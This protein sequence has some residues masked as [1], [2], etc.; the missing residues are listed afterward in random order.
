VITLEA[1]EEDP[2]PILARLLADEPVVRVGSMD[3]WFVTRW[4]DVEF[5]CHHPELFTAN[6]TPSWLRSVL[7]ETML[8]LDGEAHDRQYRAMKPPFAA[9]TAGSTVR[10][11]LPQLFDGLIDGFVDRGRAE[12]ITDYAEPLAN[13]ALLI[14]LGLRTVGW[15]DMARWCRGLCIGISNF[16]ND[17]DKA[18]LA[19][20]ARVELA[21]ALD[22]E[23]A[24]P[25][26]GLAQ[27][28]AAGL[29][30]DEI[31]NNV[32]LMISGGINEPRDGVGLVVY[33]LLCSSTTGDWVLVADMEVPPSPSV[34]C[35]VRRQCADPW[36]EGPTVRSDLVARRRSHARRREPRP[37]GGLRHVP[38]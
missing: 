4:G 24:D 12:L 15:Q 6:T 1:L 30:R 23:L 2:H 33:E 28:A 21:A 31:V 14:A 38:P 22:D 35:W 26:G 17:P 11:D 34:G 20:E 36:P 13:L 19:D 10:D 29:E 37:S 25:S 3:L 5:V 18:K 7:G 32:R 27:F 16:E 9:S 8:T